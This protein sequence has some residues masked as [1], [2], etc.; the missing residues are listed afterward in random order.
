MTDNVQTGKN[1]L[2]TCRN[3]F[4]QKVFQLEIGYLADHLE[5]YSNILSVG[6]GPAI[7]EGTLTEL[8]FI[9]T[10]LDVSREALSCAP[11]KIRTVVAR[12]EDMSFPPNSFD[13]VIYVA[14]L[15][16]IDD[17]RM[18]I[19]KTVAVLRPN[20]KLVVMLLNP[21]SMFF[22]R[23]L[24]DPDSYI[25]KIKHTDLKAMEDTIAE[26][27]TVHSEY[28]LCIDGD[29]VSPGANTTDAALY[30]ISGTKNAQL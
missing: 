14:S 25:K 17:Y 20:G 24:Q 16:F 13:A 21:A 28:F 30:I 11:D 12:A 9:V 27:F 23:K 8:G 1:Y 5:G 3:E 29:D 26:N 10:G 19:K 6:C 4:W 2:E 7:I 18:A 15:Q 22:K